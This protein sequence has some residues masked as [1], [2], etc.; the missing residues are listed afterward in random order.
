M[1]MLI[2]SIRSTLK[3]KFQLYVPARA[4][5]VPF[6]RIQPVFVHFLS[7]LVLPSECSPPGK[8]V[9]QTLQH[10]TFNHAS[11]VFQFNYSDFSHNL[12]FVLLEKELSLT[13]KGSFEG[14]RD[15]ML[16]PDGVASPSG[17][18]TFHYIKYAEPTLDVM[19]PKKRHYHPVCWKWT[20]WWTDH[21]YLSR[22]WEEGERVNPLLFFSLK[23]VVFPVDL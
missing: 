2:R 14:T 16:G 4:F 17:P 15:I 7:L 8:A 20:L 18:T 23:H 6:P 13:V 9:V 12:C 5:R 10:P 21:E 22:K 1:C 3:L 19:L 11:T